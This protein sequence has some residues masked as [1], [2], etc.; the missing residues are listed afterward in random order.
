MKVLNS[1]SSLILVLQTIIL[2]FISACSQEPE[3]PQP[4]VT[5]TAFP[6]ILR[7]GSSSEASGLAHLVG[8]HYSSEHGQTEI[9]FIH[10]NDR[11][12]LEDVAS[13]EID[14][15]F[16]YYLPADS[17]LW[18]NPVALDGLVFVTHP[19]NP[20]PNLDFS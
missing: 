17:P 11:T 13:G 14:A 7:I 2:I 20:I 4:S 10:G 8:E 5:P 12:L 19:A 3:T 6:K 15:G 18:F 9:K 16:V 1:N